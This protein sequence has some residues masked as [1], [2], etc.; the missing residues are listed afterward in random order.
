MHAFLAA[1]TD[2][3][4]D[5][6]SPY[7]FQRASQGMQDQNMISDGDRLD[8][9]ELLARHFYALDGLNQIVPGSAARNWAETFTVNG[10]F[11][12]ERS[13]KTTVVE[14]SG[15][16]NLEQLF[17]KFTDIETTRHWTNGLIIQPVSDVLVKAGCYIIALDIGKNPSPTIRSG[18]YSDTITKVDGKW[19]YDHRCLTLDP[20]SPAG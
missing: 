18:T 7:Q 4:V 16:D 8:I 20:A 3:S 15:R 5:A 19:L 11:R 10:S 6:R 14:L 13:D 17:A 1:C 2:V 9:Y 12:L